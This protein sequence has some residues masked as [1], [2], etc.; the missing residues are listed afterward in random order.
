MF[1][2]KI[3]VENLVCHSKS[4][5]VLYEE[6]QWIFFSDFSQTLKEQSGNFGGKIKRTKKQA[7]KWLNILYRKNSP[8]CMIIPVKLSK[9]FA[10]AWFQ[11][12]DLAKH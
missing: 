7:S 11:V 4:K 6:I 2:T 1:F 3:R 10:F 12:Y 9:I 5:E 8:N